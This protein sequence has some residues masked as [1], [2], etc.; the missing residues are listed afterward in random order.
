M[1]RVV[2]R[3]TDVEATRMSGAEAI[4]AVAGDILRA[5]L[6]HAPIPPVRTRLPA[7]DVEAAYRVQSATVTEWQRQGRRVVGRKIG[8]TAKTVQAQLGVDQPDYG[9]LFS[10]M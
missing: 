5:Y 6:D 10:D 2:V 9:T 1:E 4:H 8:L 7:N 3:S